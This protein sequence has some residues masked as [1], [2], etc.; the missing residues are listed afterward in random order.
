MVD[1]LNYPDQEDLAS[2]LEQAYTM[3]LTEAM[4]EFDDR[5][6][7]IG[8]LVIDSI[9]FTGEFGRGKATEGEDG[10]E[11]IYFIDR[12]GG[13]DP[14]NIIR[15]T[16]ITR[17]LGET[18][19]EL[20]E[21]PE[22]MLQMGA[23]INIRVL[24]ADNFDGI[25]ESSIMDIDEG[26]VYDIYN[27]RVCGLEPKDPVGTEVV[28]KS[29]EEYLGQEDVTEEGEQKDEITG[30]ERRILEQA[31]FIEPEEPPEREEEPE[32]IPEEALTQRELA[33]Q[34]PDIPLELRDFAEPDG[35]LEIPAGKETKQVD[36]RDMY[37]FERE[38]LTPGEGDTTVDIR[39]DGIGFA[40][41]SGQFGTGE[42]VPATY[43]RTGTY[44]KWYLYYQGPAY[45]LQM[46]NDLVIYS[47]Y[48]RG[49]HGVDAK[50]GRYSSFRN[51]I[52]R[53]LKI[54]KE[55]GPVLIRAISEE[56]ASAMGLETLPDHPTIEGEKAPWLESRQ[57]YEINEDNMGHG[58]W[59]N[60]TEYLYKVLEVAE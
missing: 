32:P 56:Q 42:F 10:F 47:G 24:D 12:Q 1:I 27:K 8:E 11:V 58:A 43:P 55:G 17:F 36:P 50:A 48:I 38:L 30:E 3:A 41:A 49:V 6:D 44:V 40:I 14:S 33:E 54:G 23:G 51:Y 59:D 19:L 25:V 31:G 28:C 29:L 22:M 60:P 52:Q 26:R 34:F 53:L 15:L 16:R 20:F 39:Q 21:P 57:Y 2:R 4:E 18:I 9:V 7:A 35:V 5:E 13:Q 37:D 45:I 46:Y